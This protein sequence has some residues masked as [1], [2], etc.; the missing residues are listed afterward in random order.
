MT[1][2]TPIS[3]NFVTG[4]VGIVHQSMHAK[5]EVRNLSPWHLTHKFYGVT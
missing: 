3:E 2:A 1:L 5:F 4:H